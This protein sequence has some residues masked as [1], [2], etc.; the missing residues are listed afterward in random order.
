MVVID[1]LMY[2][3]LAELICY[4]AELLLSQNINKYSISQK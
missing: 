3:V 1:M 4:A 2:L